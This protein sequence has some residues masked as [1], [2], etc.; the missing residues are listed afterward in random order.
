MRTDIEFILVDPAVFWPPKEP[1]FPQAPIPDSPWTYENGSVNPALIPSNTT[2]LRSKGQRSTRDTD[3][4]Y[5]LLPYHPDFQEDAAGARGSAMY[6]DEESGDEL[7]DEE[8][9]AYFDSNRGRVQVRQGSEGYEVKPVSRAEMLR[10]YME[11]LNAVPDRYNRYEPE[12]HSESEDEDDDIPLG[13]VVHGR[14][15]GTVQL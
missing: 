12:P 6:S 15:E 11:E 13:E 5:N 10:Q 8:G 4:V 9:D 14:L 7:D 1:E 3:G 2:R